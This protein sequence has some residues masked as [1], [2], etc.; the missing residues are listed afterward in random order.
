VKRELLLDGLHCA[1]CALKIENGVK[2]IQGVSECSV[3]FVTKILSMHTTSDMDEQ[4]VEEAKRK[5]RRLEPHIRIP[6][7]GKAAGQTAGGVNPDLAGHSLSNQY[8]HGHEH[9]SY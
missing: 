7:K 3:N 1:N 8:A 2:K 5:V 9:G 4:V 6:E